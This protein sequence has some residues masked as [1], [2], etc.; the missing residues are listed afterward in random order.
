METEHPNGQY[1]HI[2]NIST[3]LLFMHSNAVCMHK[4]AVMPF[5]PLTVHFK[6]DVNIEIFWWSAKQPCNKLRPHTFI[7]TSHICTLLHS[8]ILKWRTHSSSLKVWVCAETYS[9]MKQSRFYCCQFD[10]CEYFVSSICI[11][12]TFLIECNAI[13]IGFRNTNT[14]LIFIRTVV[15]IYIFCVVTYMLCERKNVG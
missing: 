4:C 7:H 2:A 14:I 3:F 10:V 8:H 12:N 9:R 5:H 15:S 1:K 11:W 6:S 13:T